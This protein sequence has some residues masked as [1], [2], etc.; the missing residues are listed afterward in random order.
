MNLNR[1]LRRLYINSPLVNEVNLTEKAHHYV[2]N[3]LRQQIGDKILFFNGID[4]EWCGSLTSFTKKQ[5][6]FTLETQ[7]REQPL[8]PTLNF[9]FAPLKKDRLDYLVQKAV[10]TGAGVLQPVITAY[11]Q[12]NKLDKLQD[13]A[14]EAAEQCGILTVPKVLKTLSFEV[15]ITNFPKDEALIFCDEQA[16]VKNPLQAL[17]KINTHKTLFIGPEGGF[18]ESERAILLSKPFVTAISLGKNILRAD[19]AAVAGMT[20]LGLL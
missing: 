9:A 17:E 11:T 8:T 19:T 14:I 3:V 15:F 5:A 18:S 4:G 6:I 12:N 2:I 7:L 20:I 10:E 13:Y 1:T 16:E